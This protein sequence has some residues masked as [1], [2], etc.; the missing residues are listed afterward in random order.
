MSL[1]E[2]AAEIQDELA[3]LRR[4]LH[5]IPEEGLHLPRTQE[6]VLAALEPLP[7]EISTGAG[8]SSITAVLRGGAPG[9]AVLLRGDMDALP[10]TESSGVDYRSRHDG[11]MHACG[12]DLHTAGLV[13]AARLLAARR[14]E[15][16]GDVVFMFQPGEEGYNGAG[17]MI[18]EG[19]LAAAGRPVEAAYGLHVLSSILDRGVFSSRPGPLMAGSAGLFVTVVGA[20]GHGSR[21]HV[22]LD[23]VPVACEMV[24]ALQTM[25]TRR[26]DA[27]EPVVLTVGT[28]HAGTRRNVIPDEATFEATVRA[29]DPSVH[30]ELGRHAVRLCEQIAAAHGLRAEVRYEPEYPVTVNDPVEHEFAATTVRE[31]FGA[32]RFTDM[33]HPMTGSEDFSRVLG[34]V[35]GAF[36]FLGAC[37]TDDPVTAPGNHSPRAVYDDSVLADGAALLAE[38]AARR[39]G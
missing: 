20:G 8:L 17:H 7:L 32:E 24:T 23:P 5:Q 26:F 27:F 25:V 14:A 19:V 15:L 12:H 10:I 21:P 37:A 2:D 13:G 18:D 36:V 4:E 28:F 39:L 6:R 1:R 16:A 29:F 11:V 30:D 9:P 34:R 33:R 31:M 38:L 22:T 3:G 35:P